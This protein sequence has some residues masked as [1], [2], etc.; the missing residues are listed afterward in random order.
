VCVGV[1]GR[2]ARRRR[3]LTTTGRAYADYSECRTSP[4]STPASVAV[5]FL[6]FS[7]GVVADPF[8]VCHWP[9]S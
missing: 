4:V 2:A 5:A 6:F 8:Y 3:V 7:F 9:L 1:V